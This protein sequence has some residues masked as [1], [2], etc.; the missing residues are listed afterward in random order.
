MLE[1]NLFGQNLRI[2]GLKTL[3]VGTAPSGLDTVRGS[4]PCLHGRCGPLTFSPLRKSRGPRAGSVMPVGA[5]T[6][7][8]S[9]KTLQ[10]MK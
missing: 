10:K 8:L 3:A 4:T 2:F 7:V 9:L 1:I 6:R 5:R